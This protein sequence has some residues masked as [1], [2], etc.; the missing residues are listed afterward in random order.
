[1]VCNGSGLFSGVG[2]AGKTR[3]LMWLTRRII[4]NPKH[5]TNEWRTL[6]YDPILNYRY[7]FDRIPFVNL[8]TM[9]NIPYATD[10][11]LDMSELNVR[12][13]QAKYLAIQL[14][15]FKKAKERK[16]AHDGK[17]PYITFHIAD[18]WHNILG[19]YALT[20]KSGDDM[21]EIITTGRNFGETYIGVTRR[22]SDLAATLVESSRTFLLGLTSGENDLQK[23]EKMTNRAVR[24]AVS[25]LKPRSFVFFDKENEI[26]KEIGFPEW[27][28]IGKPYELEIDTSNGYVIDI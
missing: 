4:D 12:E 1:M 20:G 6:I 16:I 7:F 18:E 22:L 17:V 23:I 19:R 25:A 3:A 27:I 11:V 9:R 14:T 13:K 21:R 8:K 5:G 26:I 28:Q 15:E 24:N 10:L 2:G